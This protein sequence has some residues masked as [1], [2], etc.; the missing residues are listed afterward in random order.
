MTETPLFGFR[1]VAANATEAAKIGAA[2][3]NALL[4]ESLF[5]QQ[6][7]SRSTSAPPGSP[8][9]GD[10]Y[11]IPD[12]ASSPAPSGAWAGHGNKIT[13]FYNG[14][15]VA[16]PVQG[17]RFWVN[18]ESVY[19]HFD[20]TG[21]PSVWTPLGGVNNAI[22]DNV[23]G[24]IAALTL[25]GSPVAGDHVLIEDSE[26]ANNKKRAAWPSG[27]GFGSFCELSLLS[28][29]HTHNT[30]KVMTW[31]EID[32]TDNYFDSGVST[33]EINAPF[34]GR[35]RITA[36]LTWEA[37][38]AAWIGQSAVRLNR[39]GTSFD[40]DFPGLRNDQ[41]EPSQNIRRHLK[42][43]GVISLT[44]TNTIDVIAFHF[45]ATRNTDVK[46]RLLIEFLG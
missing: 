23:A 37:L 46:G 15:L 35:Y 29:S 16:L 40:D 34:T 4:F 27:G 44:A 22:H 18:D 45:S 43:A 2:N 1:L 30:N 20:T 17:P 14:W 36:N 5:K 42:F 12:P 32:D 13:I 21:S 24:E 11:I 9:D 41:A 26:N 7:I 39:A 33:E 28:A 3:E 6:V 10:V 31:A 19:V 38:S 8:T 25:K